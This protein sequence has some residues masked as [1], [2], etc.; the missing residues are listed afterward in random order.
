[1][2]RPLLSLLVLLAVAATSQA[3]AIITF[4]NLPG[5][6]STPFP[7]PY[8]EAGYTVTST[9]GSWFQGLLFG[10]PTPSIFSDSDLASVEVT[11]DGGGLFTFL[12]VDMADA[13][14]LDPD[15]PDYLFEGFR[16][17]N[18]IYSHA[19]GPLPVGFTTVNNPSDATNIDLL[20]ITMTRVDTTDY[21]L[22]NITLGP[23]VNVPEPAAL[24]LFGGFVMAGLAGYRR[25]QIKA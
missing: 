12:Q 1:M 19:G 9:A 24:V 14:N 3:S 21:N 8:M 10:N 6:T 11:Q 2:R 15:G 22:D 7:S 13:F 17:G 4:D 25:R 16:N 20:R 18:L 5:G 23:P